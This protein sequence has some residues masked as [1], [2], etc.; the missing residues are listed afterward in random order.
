MPAVRVRPATAT[1][2]PHLARLWHEKKV[3]QQQSDPRV[4]L[5]ED[6]SAR[7]LT[8]AEA[9]M[10]DSRCSLWVA[11]R[12]DEI[13][14][15]VLGRLEN[16]SPGE[17]PEHFGVVVDL[18]VDAHARQGGVGSLLLDALREWFTAHGAANII[19]YVSSR[20][21]VEQAF[22]RSQGAADWIDLLWL[23]S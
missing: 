13:L 21:A 12:D 17:I 10:T 5:A 2:L 4:R 18:A 9:W 1:D 19:A 14:G 20:N 22:W 23:K 3:I 11:L 7:W 6:A 16:A 8:A 15:Y